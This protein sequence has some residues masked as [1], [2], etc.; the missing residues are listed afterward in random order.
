MRAALLAFQRDFAKYDGAVLD[1]R[2]IGT[3]IFPDATVKLFVTASPWG[4]G[5]VGDGWNC[6]SKGTDADL[7]TVEEDM[8]R[9]DAKDAARATAPLRPADDAYQLDTTTMDAEAAFHAALAF[10][11]TQ[12]DV[13]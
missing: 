12:I 13:G 3:V 6:D 11:R 5:R 9:R 4:N 10:I 1:G 2:D 7:A 8:R